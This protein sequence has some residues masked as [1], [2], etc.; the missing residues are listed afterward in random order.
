MD[1]RLLLLMQMPLGLPLDQIDVEYLLAPELDPTSRS[2]VTAA[3]MSLAAKNFLYANP[4]WMESS[5]QMLKLGERHG[6]RW[7]YQGQ[8]EY[9]EQWTKLSQRPVIFNFQG[10][11]VW[12]QMPLL[13]VVGSRT[14]A[15]A[16][17]LWMQRELSH[18][19]RG[20]NLGVV[21]GGARGVDQWAHR[22]AIECHRPTVCIL[23]SGLLNPYPFERE[24]LWRQIR[25]KGGCM[26][27]TCGL[28]EPMRKS[29][30]H[31]RNRWI[32]GLSEMCFV[33]EANRRSGSMLT[34][35]LANEEHKTVCTL[36]VFPTA[37]QG[38][39]NL[40][41]ISQ[42]AF[43]LRDH[44]DLASLWTTAEISLRASLASID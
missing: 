27:S 21:S 41:L 16:T 36:P 22:L 19:L 11:P 8:S 43:F 15:T 30:F 33:A 18:F 7:A 10:E 44:K 29:F 25:D 35:R 37:N 5:Y 12:K 3:V 28:Q 42:G 26:L 13:S 40:D 34:A 23:P 1:Y 39:G 6:I 14:P 9:P 17:L 38:L 20:H 31:I 24:D 2:Q 32:A 4:H